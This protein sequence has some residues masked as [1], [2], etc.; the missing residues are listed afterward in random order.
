MSSVFQDY[1]TDERPPRNLIRTWYS[2]QDAR[3]RATF[4]GTVGLIESYSSDDWDRFS[5]FKLLERE[6][7]GL[8]ELVIDIKDRKPFRHIRPLGVWHVEERLFV[9]LGAFEKSG[10]IYKP[11]DACKEALK[12]KA[13]YENGRGA[14]DDHR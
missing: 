5:P 7:A 3:V 2:L 14:I 13:Q 1:Y 8:W 6:C 10:Y 4:D 9:F 11:S 12:Y